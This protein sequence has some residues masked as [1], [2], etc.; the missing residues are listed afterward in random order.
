MI[1]PFTYLNAIR[2][3]SH[4]PIL[5]TSGTLEAAKKYWE[6]A[7]KNI[8]GDTLKLEACR[9][10]NAEAVTALFETLPAS[11]RKLDF[12]AC[13]FSNS[14]Y[15]TLI[16]T[17]KPSCELDIPLFMDLLFDITPECFNN[18]TKLT[19]RPPKVINAE[20]IEML[21]LFLEGFYSQT[22][23]FSI[24]LTHWQFSP[25]QEKN[26]SSYAA[27][28]LQWNKFEFQPILDS[29]ADEIASRRQSATLRL[30]DSDC[31]AA[32]D[33]PLYF[34]IVKEK[35]M[36]IKTLDLTYLVRFLTMPGTPL[37]RL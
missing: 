28:G 11:I 16:H 34:Q 10:A 27:K 15:S 14:A 19:L 32:V 3:D 35:A 21:I 7:F 29:E 5:T 6:N 36:T 25:L 17:P 9:I 31:Y 30:N 1:S 22:E 4:T 20:E 13:S 33:S 24:D 37:C 12:S 8:T 18:I 2:E 26:L 23:K